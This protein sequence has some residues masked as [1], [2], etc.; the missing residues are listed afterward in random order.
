MALWINTDDGWNE[1]WRKQTQLYINLYIL[2]FYLRC[3]AINYYLDIHFFLIR[4]FFFSSVDMRTE[5]VNESNDVLR[6][7]SDMQQHKSGLICV[8]FCTRQ[9]CAKHSIVLMDIPFALEHRVLVQNVATSTAKMCTAEEDQR[10]VT[11]VG[12]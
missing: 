3:I 7:T 12:K 4:F 2:H 1:C 10:L 11:S 8:Q 5:L 6:I 9:F